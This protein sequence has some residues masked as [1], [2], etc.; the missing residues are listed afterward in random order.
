MLFRLLALLCAAAMLA[1]PF[2]AW[3]S[4]PLGESLVPWTM[5]RAMTADQ[6]QTLARNATP[7]VIA[8]LASFLLAA[9]F[10]LLA[11]IGR[12]SR[13]MAFLTGLAPVGLVA[14]ALIVASGRVYFSH[15]PISAEKLPEGLVGTTEVLGP[16][17]WAW[18]GGAVLLLLLGLFD[19]GRRTG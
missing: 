5:V 1:S 18:I 4:P 12:E 7:A 2:L 3:F 13:T 9:V 15:L 19:P 17:A 16:G 11:L 6:I 14:W 8:F 10:V